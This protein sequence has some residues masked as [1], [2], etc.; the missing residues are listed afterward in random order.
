MDP[1]V[2]DAD[3]R[4]DGRDSFFLLADVRRVGEEQEYRTKV[5]NLSAG[6]LMAEGDMRVI[7]GQAIEV[8]LRNLGWVEG[9]VAWVQDNRFGVA[10][11]SEIDPKLARSPLV[12]GESTPRFVKPAFGTY[13]AGPMRKV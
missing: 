13:A 11:L 2:T 1:Q 5:R 4:H 3:H 8:A 9:V 12:A 6:G 10:F 7:R